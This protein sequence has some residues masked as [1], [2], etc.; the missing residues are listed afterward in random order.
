MRS[1]EILRFDLAGPAHV[2]GPIGRVHPGGLN[3]R[4]LAFLLR[5]VRR[6][7]SIAEAAVPLV[8]IGPVQ[9]R[10]DRPHRLVD[11]VVQITLAGETLRH[12]GD[13]EVLGLHVG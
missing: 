12:G 3:A 1:A 7:R 11:A 10:F 4:R 5:E 2:I 9:Q 6:I 13:G 8:S